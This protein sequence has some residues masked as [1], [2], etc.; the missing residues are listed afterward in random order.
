MD[1]TATEPVAPVA[2]GAPPVGNGETQA[3]V[4][5]IVGRIRPIAFWFV[6][7]TA[8][9]FLP[10]GAADFL[11]GRTIDA[12]I[13]GALNLGAAILWFATAIGLRY[14]TLVTLGLAISGGVMAVVYGSY[15]A[16]QWLRYQG[17]DDRVSVL[18]VWMIAIGAVVLL[19]LWGSWRTYG[20]TTRTRRRIGAGRI[21]I[22]F[23]AVIG[24]FGAVFQFWYSAAYG[25]S[26]LPPNLVIEARLT[27]AGDQDA[28]GLRAYSVNV[29]VRNAGQARVQVL[30]S[31][32]NVA[33]VTASPTPSDADY[34]LDL[35]SAFDQTPWAMQ[36][37]PHR[38][39]RLMTTDDAVVVSSGE[40]L[41]RGWYFEPGE[42]SNVQF[43][44]YVRP[45]D[46]DVL[47]LGVGIDM[48]RGSRLIEAPGTPTYPSDCDADP[49]PFDAMLW[50]SDEP[51]MIRSFTAPHISVAYGWETV[52]GVL[53]FVSCYGVND[54]WHQPPGTDAPPD[55][56]LTSLDQEYGFAG[57]FAE[58]QVSLWPSGSDAT[59]SG[60][61]SP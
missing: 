52:D 35:Q 19:I 61:T 39:A 41:A 2:G 7:L 58:T 12:R 59:P 14:R 27:P 44:T 25:P 1:E 57:T 36:I 31:W 21:G 29:D 48:A 49:A 22:P 47:Y 40:L 38:A 8:A 32:F 51:S 42:T 60:S 18:A 53:G 9:V 55:P 33:V 5:A 43:L 17:T 28:S 13:L 46:G 45:A 10:I 30:A 15:Y 11:G 20:L 16:W 23:L 4:S 56:V 37:Q 54:T 26:A 6:L 34:A 50:T 3:R 24:T